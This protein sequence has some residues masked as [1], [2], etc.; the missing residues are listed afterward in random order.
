MKLKCLVIDLYSDDST[1]RYVVEA[2]FAKRLYAQVDYYSSKSDREGFSEKPDFVIFVTKMY[3]VLSPSTLNHIEWSIKQYIKELTERY[4]YMKF[5][6]YFVIFVEFTLRSHYSNHESSLGSPGTKYDIVSETGDFVV[7]SFYSDRDY[8]ISRARELIDIKLA[9]CL[10][11]KYQE[12]GGQHVND[13]IRSVGLPSCFISYP[14]CFISYSSKDEAFARQLHIDLQAVGVQCWFAPEDMKIGDELRSRIDESIHMQDKLLLVLSEHSL[15]SRWVQKEV[16][17]A[18]EKEAKQDCLVLFPIKIDDAIMK[19]SAGW[20][21][22]IRRMRHIGDFSQWRN[23]ETYQ[24]AL[25]RLIRDLG[26][27]VLPQAG[28]G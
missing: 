8:L 25:S 2:L 28:R 5:K 19:S 27:Q 4:Q 6:S 20:A 9:L 17:S 22:D 16:E 23:H 15:T 12:T 18:F 13:F 1:T 26:L 11:Q 7:G 3:L 14:S 10:A 24:Q 21:A